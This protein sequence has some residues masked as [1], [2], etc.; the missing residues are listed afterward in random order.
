MIGWLSRIFRPS[1]VRAAEGEYRPGPWEVSGGWLPASWGANWNFW[2]NG[3][4]PLP[5]GATSSIVQACVGAYAETIAMCPG[6]HWVSLEN[7]GRERNKASALTRI[8]KRPNGYQ[9]ISDFLLNLVR[10]LMEDGNA[11]AV[12]IRNGRGEIAELHLMRSRMCSARVAVDGSLFY[13]LSGNEVVDRFIPAGLMA[14]VPQRDVLHV[15][16][17][18]RR[19][20]LI[21]ESPI[22][23]SAMDIGLSAL[24]KQQQAA[25]FANG[26][27]PSAV[28][29][30]DLTL[31]VGQVADLRARWNEQSQGMSAGGVPILTS[32]LKP[33]PWSQSS[34][35]SQLAEQLK[36]SDQAV[37]L[38]F[39]TPLAILGLGGQTY[40]STEMLMRQWIATGLGFVLNHI[41]EAVGNLFELR[42]QPDEY[43]EL[44]TDALLRSDFKTRIEGLARATISGIM[45]TNEA[46]RSENLPAVPFGNEVRVQQQVV[47]LSYGANLEPP[48]PA[49]A[50]P[51]APP[52]AAND[53][54]NE[55]ADEGEEGETEDAERHFEFLV[56]EEADRLYA[57]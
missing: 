1:A 40:S 38:A 7:G 21:G 48:K 14:A 22:L 29:T 52:P 51:A 16:L 36:M 5:F 49:P 32:G 10:E 46:R 45:A 35:D 13:A 42:G 18:C 53:D 26:G 41:E 15:R 3:Y 39:R 47:P 54:G 50:T 33:Q 56:L 57:G 12:A 44:N 23:A 4:N 27:R 6:D 19:H 2:Q 55:P 20:P 28:L 25:F 11:Y 43:L 31:D 34:V 9:S 37:A 17:H 30:T 24:M 8:L